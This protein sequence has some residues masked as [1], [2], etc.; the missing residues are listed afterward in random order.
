MDWLM[1]GP[2]S[3]RCQRVNGKPSKRSCS[4]S[5]P[6]DPLFRDFDCL[7][8]DGQSLSYSSA[9]VISL[10]LRC[11]GM[12]RCGEFVLRAFLVQRGL[13]QQPLPVVPLNGFLHNL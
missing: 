4:A 8:P 13:R 7:M 6:S 12:P 1:P 3:L 2:R 9:F 10:G 5:P 11:L